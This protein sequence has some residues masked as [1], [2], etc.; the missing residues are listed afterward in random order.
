MAAKKKG[1][2]TALQ[3]IAVGMKEMASAEAVRPSPA[4]RADIASL[5]ATVASGFDAVLAELAKKG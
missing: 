2:E 1:P 5:H 4:T 3:R